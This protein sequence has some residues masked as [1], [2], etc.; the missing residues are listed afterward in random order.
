MVSVQYPPDDIVS[1]EDACGSPF[2]AR[3]GEVHEALFRG[4]L[5]DS[6][7]S[8]DMDAV[9]NGGFPSFGLVGQQEVR[10]GFQRQGDRLASTRAKL[11]PELCP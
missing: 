3:L 7:G 2:H 10:L 1:Q 8:L 6:E 4:F 5:Q 11:R 9:R